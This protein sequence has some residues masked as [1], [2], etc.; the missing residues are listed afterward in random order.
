VVVWKAA[1]MDLMSLASSSR[2]SSSR[3]LGVM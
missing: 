3:M 1:K 2:G